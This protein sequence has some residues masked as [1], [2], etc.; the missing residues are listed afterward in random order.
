ML[1]SAQLPA[2]IGPQR[3][4][5]NPVYQVLGHRAVALDQRQQPVVRAQLRVPKLLL[6]LL[7][8]L[9]QAAR[10]WTEGLE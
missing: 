1:P 10:P 9:Y 4:G 5:L 2:Q 8:G 6:P 7:G 3:F